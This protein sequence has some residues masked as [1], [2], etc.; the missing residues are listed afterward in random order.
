MLGIA[1]PAATWRW[2]AFGKHPLA[3][4]YFS[5]GSP[6][7]LFQAFSTWVEGGYR[8]LEKDMKHSTDLHSWRFC[9]KGPKHDT[10]IC[11]VGRDSF[12]T[13]GRPYPLFIMGTGALPGISKHWEL[14][15][16]ALEPLWARMEYLGARRYIDF[17]QMKE[18]TERLPPPE[19][20][21]KAHE[22]E[23]EKRRATSC[24]NESALMETVRK[25]VFRHNDATRFTIPTDGD[26]RD[27]TLTASLCFSMMK[28]EKDIMPGTLFPGGAVSA[29]YLI[30]FRRPLNTGD[31]VGLWS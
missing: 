22:N 11:G 8:Q 15:P 10:L 4:D 21:W 31:F 12:D 17:S 27:A 28:A 7:P 29:T 24:P 5:L 19:K 23:R 1:K 13:V 25:S 14:L 9:G 20:R 3:G 18:D 2:T 16:V 6:D 30:G 26:C